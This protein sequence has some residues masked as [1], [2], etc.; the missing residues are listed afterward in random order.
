MGRCSTL[1]ALDATI[2]HERDKAICMGWDHERTRDEANVVLHEHLHLPPTHADEEAWTRMTFAER[3]ASLN[4][5][6]HDEALLTEGPW[7]RPRDWCQW[8]AA[9][10]TGELGRAAYTVYLGET[11]GEAL[12]ATLGFV[13]F[14]RRWLAQDDVVLMYVADD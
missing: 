5:S 6:K 12:G 11:L 4:D 1:Y 14:A 8:C 10:A 13:D 3:K 9:L 2:V 7:E